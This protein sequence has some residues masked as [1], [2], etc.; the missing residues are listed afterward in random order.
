[1]AACHSQCLT[2]TNSK[3]TLVED[4]N[5]SIARLRK[6]LLGAQ[7]EKST[8]IFNDQDQDSK[9]HSTTSD[10]SDAENTANSDAEDGGG[11]APT[12]KPAEDELA[13][14]EEPSADDKKPPPQNHGRHSADDYTG[15][16]QVEIKHPT[17]KA[18]DACPEC[19]QGTLYGKQPGV[20]VRFVGQA[21]VEATVYR[22]EKLR[23]HLC[24]KTFTAPTPPELSP[25]K[26][27][28]IV[29]SMITLLRY[30]SGLPLNRVQRPQ[31]K[32]I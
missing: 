19:Q 21:P 24:G 13:D 20:I 8:N 4:K 16:R 32:V 30:G 18:G 25:E 1:M 6:L 22:L 17:L 31:L 28:A 14:E 7:T 27:D 5:T 29:A 26:N 2:G 3:I 23:C 12:D 11:E 10:D 15:G 9:N